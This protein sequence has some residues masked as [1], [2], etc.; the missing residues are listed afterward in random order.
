MDLTD[1]QYDF[2]A[3]NLVG[4]RSIPLEQ[5]LELKKRDP[6]LQYTDYTVVLDRRYIDSHDGEYVEG[7]I[8]LPALSGRILLKRPSL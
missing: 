5:A 1:E 8:T 6:D 4:T 3:D 7:E 2:L